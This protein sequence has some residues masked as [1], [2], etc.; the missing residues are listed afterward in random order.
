MAKIE[1]ILVVDDDPTHNLI[2]EN[3]L[4]ESGISQEVICMLNTEDAM[5]YLARLN[6]GEFPEYIFL[7]IMFPTNTGWH[8][9]E[10]YKKTF[11]SRK[12]DTRIFII[13]SS[14]SKSDWTR[15]KEEPLVQG[16]ISKP[17]TRDKIPHV[18]G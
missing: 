17:F 2:C 16:F 18:F 5:N 8:F 6:L 15:A 7:D 3:V 11:P 10:S 13:T 14:I 9:L 4:L 12:T 1:K